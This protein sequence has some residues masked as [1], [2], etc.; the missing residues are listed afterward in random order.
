MLENSGLFKKGHRINAGKYSGSSN[1]FFGKKHSLETRLKM[2]LRRKGKPGRK[3][4]VETRKK[5]SEQRKGEKSHTW[6]GGITPENRRI[7]NS[8]EYKLWRESVFI[9][10]NFTCV[11]CFKR[12]GK[13]NADHIKP[14]AYFP[15]LRFS[16]DNGRTLCVDCHRKTD[17]WGQKARN[18]YEK[19]RS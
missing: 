10:D 2:S 9:R 13:I 4:S 18:K 14:F 5:L 1:P 8:V 7:Y 16:I 12:G 6:R 19:K 15:E 17:T 3:H 11:W